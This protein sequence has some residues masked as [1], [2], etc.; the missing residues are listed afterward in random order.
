M[1]VQN[2]HFILQEYLKK[3]YLYLALTEHF[4]DFWAENGAF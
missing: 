2:S 4:T 3:D 1:T